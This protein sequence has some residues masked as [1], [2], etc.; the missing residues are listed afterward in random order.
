[1]VFHRPV[2][3]GDEVSLYTTVEKVGRT[4][5]TI[6]VQ[7]WRRRRDDD[8]MAKVTEAKFTFVALDQNGRPRPLPGPHNQQELNHG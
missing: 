8:E 1:M 6:A 3:V 2:A 7:A 4:S 5:M